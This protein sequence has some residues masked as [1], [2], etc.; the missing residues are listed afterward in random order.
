[1]SHIIS[2]WCNS[3]LQIFKTPHRFCNMTERVRLVEILQGKNCDNY[4]RKPTKG[5]NIR[6][7]VVGQHYLNVCH[8]FGTSLIVFLSMLLISKGTFSFKSLLF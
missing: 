3:Y 1:M 5:Q 4:P 6:M 8:N 2:I 7:K